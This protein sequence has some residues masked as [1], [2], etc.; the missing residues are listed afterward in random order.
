MIAGYFPSSEGP[1][2]EAIERK[3][4]PA[5]ASA[6]TRVA[7]DKENAEI[8]KKNAEGRERVVK[9]QREWASIASPEERSLLLLI[10]KHDGKHQSR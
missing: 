7:I 8:D 4:I 9:E 1:K 10:S 2:Y 3:E 6:E 5:A